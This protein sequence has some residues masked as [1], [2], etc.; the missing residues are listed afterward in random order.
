MADPLM[1]NRRTILM[2]EDSPSLSRAYE[3]QLAPLGHEVIMVADGAS[4][5]AMLE[6]RQID[7][8]L[9]DLQLPDM[10][11]MAVLDVARVLKAPPA[12]VVIT[13]NASINMAIRAIRSG[14]IDYLVRPEPRDLLWTVGT[15]LQ[16]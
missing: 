5:L 2:V 8:I 1:S 9:L 13:S 16:N 11:G 6:T 14:A 3:T 10:D 4:A 15:H 12:V 7:C